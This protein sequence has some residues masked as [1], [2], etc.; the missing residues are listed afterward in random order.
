MHAQALPSPPIHGSPARKKHLSEHCSKERQTKPCLIP[1]SQVKV[2]RV[3]NMETARKLIDKKKKNF[4]SQA[5]CAILII[6]G[7]GFIRD[8]GC[9]SAMVGKRPIYPP[10]LDESS[11]LNRS[12]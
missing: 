4:T 11:I 10:V 12:W 8:T 3:V 1:P 9:S 7:G 6:L 2:A 5:F